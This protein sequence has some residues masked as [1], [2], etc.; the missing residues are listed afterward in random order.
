MQRSSYSVSW[1]GSMQINVVL[2]PVN[3]YLTLLSHRVPEKCSSSSLSWTRSIFALPTQ[4][5]KVMPPA[6]VI[7]MGLWVLG[8]LKVNKQRQVVNPCVVSD[9]HDSAVIFFFILLWVYIQV[10]LVIM[11]C[12]MCSK[13]PCHCFWVLF[14]IVSQIIFKFCWSI[15][16]QCILLWV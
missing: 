15:A 8:T 10:F 13:T 5:R 7:D 2:K 11:S 16:E 9:R 3:V 12:I 14:T 4:S 6:L 1:A